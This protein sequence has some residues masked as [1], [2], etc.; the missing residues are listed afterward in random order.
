MSVRRTKIVA[1][2]GPASNSPEVLEQLILAGVD[3]ARLNFS[4]ALR[5]NTRLVPNWSATWPP[6]M[7]ASSPSSVTCRARRSASLS[8]PTSASN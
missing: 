6:S 1:T 2:L 8:S 3:V 7:V 4:T 5:P